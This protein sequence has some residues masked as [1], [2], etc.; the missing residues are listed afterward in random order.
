MIA[1]IA[2]VALMTGSVV[3]WLR[4]VAIT[5]SIFP[6]STAV[7]LPVISGPFH[8]ATV[9]ME[10]GR[11]Y[12][13]RGIDVEAIHRALRANLQA[14][15]IVQGGST[16]TQQL[17][18]NLFLSND[19]TPWRKVQEMFLALALERRLTKEE[20]LTLYRNTIDYGMGQHGIKHAASFYFHTSPDQ[21]TLAQSAVLVG[22]VPA[23]PQTWLTEDQL[24]QGRQ[25]AL[26]RIAFWFPGRYSDSQRG[27]ARSLPLESFVLPYLGPGRRGATE[28]ISA[29]FEQVD[30]F[31]YATPDTPGPIAR[32]SPEL[33]AHL[34]AFLRDARE[35]CGLTGIDHLG[36]Y[37]DRPVRGTQTVPSAHAFG[38]AIDIC[39]FRFADGTHVSVADHGHP[40]SL[41]RIAPLEILLHRHFPVIISWREDLLRHDN[42]FHCEVRG[43]RHI[44][45]GTSK[46]S[47]TRS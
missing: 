36:V 41:A 1:L 47:M 30:F 17:A 39:G 33:K 15:S 14:G 13:H 37:N 8:D 4:A 16:I 22:L 25:T 23:P 11:F 45:P 32:V 3:L 35:Q 19:R 5:A 40:A 29:H 26:D 6:D 20:I 44:I 28:E 9:A 43:N 42:H 12:F 21:L 34:A 38:Q 27:A 31:F 46:T 18:K 2:L 24:E 7:R 10:D